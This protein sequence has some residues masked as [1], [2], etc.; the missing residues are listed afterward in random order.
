ME[1][2]IFSEILLRWQMRFGVPL[3]LHVAEWDNLNLVKQFMP[4]CRQL[5]G[6]IN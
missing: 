5:V 3:M 1:H 6:I 4:A 2:E